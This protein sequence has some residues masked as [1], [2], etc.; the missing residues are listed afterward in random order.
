MKENSW[1][2]CIISNSAS[3]ATPD[4]AKARSLLEMAEGRLNFLKTITTEKGNAN[5]LFEGYYS[6]LLEVM[7]AL[8]ISNG[9]KVE[10]HICLGY[11]LRDV[12]KKDMLFRIFDDVR[13]KRNRL[14]YYGKG[15][16][17]LVAEESIR[18]IKEVIKDIL[19]FMQ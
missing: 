13:I 8:A 6:S 19:R 3:K 17:F 9:F 11:Y 16:D 12:V 15:M 2:E 5:Y 4:K 7:H 18:K 1:E 14:L 10:N